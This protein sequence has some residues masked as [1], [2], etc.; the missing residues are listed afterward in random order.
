MLYIQKCI[1]S[2]TKIGQKILHVQFY[3]LFDNLDNLIHCYIT[4]TTTSMLQCSEKCPCLN[5][6]QTANPVLCR[7]YSTY[8]RRCSLGIL[9]S[10]TFPRLGFLELEA[11]VSEGS[12]SSQLSEVLATVWPQR[13]RPLF[14]T[15]NP[16]PP[17]VF[18]LPSDAAFCSRRQYNRRPCKSCSNSENPSY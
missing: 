13:R 1:Q 9:S 3:K 16:P 6:C 4:H 11:A 18:S 8:C 7:H 17:T 14:S 15:A 5:F 2:F 12:D 10:S